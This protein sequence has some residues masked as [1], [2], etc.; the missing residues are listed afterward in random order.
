M[1]DAFKGKQLESALKL[2]VQCR[3]NAYIP[4]SHFAV[5]AT[6]K[7]QSD[8]RLFTGCNV[9]NAS[10]GATICAERSAIMSAISAHGRGYIEFILVSADG[11][12]PV[13]P[14][15]ICLQVISE[16]ANDKTTIY[17]ADTHR[18]IANI[19]FQ[20]LLPYSFTSATVPHFPTHEAI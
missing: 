3:T 5:G 6:V 4:Y 10:F 9:E 18:I 15:A 19:N 2:A 16:F 17:L 13:C 8:P 11:S 20:N 14:C 12:E 7:L 1:K